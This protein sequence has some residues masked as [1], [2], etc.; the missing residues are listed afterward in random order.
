MTVTKFFGIIFRVIFYPAIVYWAI[1][2]YFFNEKNY[3]FEELWNNEGTFAASFVISVIYMLFM[4]ICF[5]AYS[6]RNS[7][8]S[9]AIAYSPPYLYKNY[10]NEVSK[11]FES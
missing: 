8:K 4:I 11:A 10:W 3:E 6:I 1:K 2:F 5:I 7:D 9:V